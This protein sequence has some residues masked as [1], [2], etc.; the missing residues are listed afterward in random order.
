MRMTARR[1]GL[2]RATYL[3]WYLPTG[4][5]RNSIAAGGPI[6]Q[7]RTG[8]GAQAMAHAAG[9]LPVSTGTPDAALPEVHFV[10][11]TKFWYQTAFCLHTL[12]VHTG[13]VFRTVFHDDGTLRPEQSASLQ[14]LFP[15]ADLRWRRDNDERVA[16]ILPPAR[17]PHLHRERV[18][19]YPNFLKLTDIHAGAT[20]WRLVLDSDML[21]FRRPDWLLAWLGAPPNPIYQPDVADAYHYPLARMD[22]LAANPVPRRVNVGIFG[23]DSGRIDWDRLEH[24]C[25][26]LLAEAGPSYYLEQ[27]LSAMLLAGNAPAPA[28]DDYVLK[29]DEEEGRTPRAVMHHY[30][31]GSKRSYFRHA[32]RVALT[33]AAASR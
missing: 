7:W 12:Q 2:G 6:A 19:P 30:V 27:A 16:T 22:A 33:R 9:S 14:T 17:F 4:I 15:S 24:W 1:L 32:W 18:R 25:A 23:I 10:T 20:G 28:P 29:P 3:L 8:R 31:A 13:R 11:G 5:I 21:F 26:Q